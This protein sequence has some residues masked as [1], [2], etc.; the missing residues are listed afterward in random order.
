LPEVGSQRAKQDFP[1]NGSS[2]FR[3]S[4]ESG[5]KGPAH[6]LLRECIRVLTD[7]LLDIDAAKGELAVHTYAERTR[8]FHAG[9][10]NPKLEA[11][12]AETLMEADRKELQR[13]L[14]NDQN[15]ERMWVSIL[16]FCKNSAD[17]QGPLEQLRS[18]GRLK[19][20]MLGL[21][22]VSKEVRK[23][24]F[25]RGFF[26]GQLKP[27]FREQE[28]RLKPNTPYRRR[29]AA[30]SDPIPYRPHKREASEP[31]NDEGRLFKRRKR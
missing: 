27:L 23:T 20:G 1:Q 10:W 9:S 6:D 21:R 7:D 3:R 14:S 19:N 26:L 17:W 18:L 8:A 31:P 13:L 24:A 11:S 25:E 16:D 5:N 2:I 12:H 15:S 28:D 4:C 29:D 22:N 30:R